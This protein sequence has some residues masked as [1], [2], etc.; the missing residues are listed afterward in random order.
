MLRDNTMMSQPLA[1]SVKKRAAAWFIAISGVTA[2]VIWMAPLDVSSADIVPVVVVAT[3][4]ALLLVVVL[5]LAITQNQPAQVIVYRL[6]LLIW[7]VILVS[8]AVFDRTGDSTQAYLSRFSVQAYGEGI[9]WMLAFLTLV[10]LSLQQPHY[11]RHL[12][13]GSYKWITL[14]AVVC[15]ASV[16]YSTGKTYAGAWAFK[17]LVVVLLLH[18]GASMLGSVSDIVTFLKVT[19]WGFFVLTIVPAVQ[20]F[21]DPSSAFEGVGGRLNASPDAL[22]LTAALLLLLSVILYSLERRKTMILTGLLASAVMLMSLGKSGILASVFSVLLFFL[23]QKQ[24]ARSMAVLLGIGAVAFVVLSVTPVAG[25][26]QSYQGAATLTGRTVIWAQG[27]SAMRQNWLFGHGYLSTYFSFYGH[28]HNGFLEVAYNN[29]SVGLGILLMIH[30]MILRNVF[31]S[32]RNAAAL[33]AERP[34][35]QESSR[36]YILAVGSLAL[37]ANLTL[38]GLFNA[39]FGGRARS[40]FMLFLA[41][42]VMVDLLRRNI[43]KDLGGAAAEVKARPADWLPVGAPARS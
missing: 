33:R 36:A 12:F 39:T 23:L 34:R 10:V 37:Y 16:S 1:V 25:H 4:F 11:L 8:E 35:D 28:L 24:V 13:S 40:P 30:F 29:G 42:F 14:F 32:I 18:L 26:L 27:I 7:W 31:L 15:L 2:L 38:N 20:A 6:T 43:A 3:L 5:G 19:L 22:T 21:S 17:L 41:V 9:V